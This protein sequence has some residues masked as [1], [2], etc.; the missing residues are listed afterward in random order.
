MSDRNDQD[1]ALEWSDQERALREERLGL[2]SA[3]GE[4]RVAQYRLLARMLSEPAGD[5]LP[6]N[7]AALVA[8]RADA[9]SENAGDR[10]EIWVQRV[11]LAVLALTCLAFFDGDAVAWLQRVFAGNAG[12]ANEVR[13]TPA[14]RWVLAIGLC[15]A[16]SLLIE[17]WTFLADQRQTRLKWRL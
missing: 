11:L 5:S 8:A 17:F 6:Y 9:A 12:G 3:F 2:G 13:A 1:A 16:L 14:G 10:V 4:P 15:I 7:F